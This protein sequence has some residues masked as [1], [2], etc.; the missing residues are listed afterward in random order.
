MKRIITHV[1]LLIAAL[2]PAIAQQPEN[3]YPGLNIQVENP[4][5]FGNGILLDVILQN[6]TYS[7]MTLSF[8]KRSSQTK[9]RG[10]AIDGNGNKYYVGWWQLVTKAPLSYNL[11]PN[12]AVRGQIIIEDVPS[13]VGKINLLDIGVGVKNNRTEY[14]HYCFNDIIVPPLTNTDNANTTCTYPDFYISPLSCTRVNNNIEMTF[15]VTNKS[16]MTIDLK[17]F[18][19]NIFS[20]HVN[21]YD[22]NGRE[23]GGRLHSWSVESPNTYIFPPEVPVKLKLVIKDVPKNV[24]SFQLIRFK[25]RKIPVDF[26]IDFRNM[27]VGWTKPQES[28]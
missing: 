24:T 21:A 6:T 11:F 13:N 17:D 19:Y 2:L 22:L 9:E 16:R 27:H 7:P 23:Y 15:L 3:K 14:L 8:P 18:G 25:F 1:I 12:T 5:H 28:N 20:D 26:S 10:T 4:R